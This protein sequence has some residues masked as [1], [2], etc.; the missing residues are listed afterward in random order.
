MA[1][2]MGRCPR[3]G[4]DVTLE[5]DGVISTPCT[6]N[7]LPGRIARAARFYACNF[8]E[9]IEEVKKGRH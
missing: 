7:G 8:C 3:C 1:L 6:V 4:G 2:K 5:P 9:W